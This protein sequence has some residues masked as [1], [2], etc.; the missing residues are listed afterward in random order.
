MSINE[1][2]DILNSKIYVDDGKIMYSTSSYVSSKY[3]YHPYTDSNSTLF[4]IAFVKINSTKTWNKILVLVQYNQN[5]EY[6]I[7]Q[8]IIIHITNQ[9]NNKIT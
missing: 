1:L 9:H 8:N 6:L 7:M 2:V 4:V 5:S 3:K